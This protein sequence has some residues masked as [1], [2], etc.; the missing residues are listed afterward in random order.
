MKKSLFF[1][2]VAVALLAVSCNDD[3]FS[4]FPELNDNQLYYAGE[5]LNISP[6]VSIQPETSVPE[7]NY[8]DP[9]KYYVDFVTTD[10]RVSARMD[11]QPSTIG[12]TVDMADPIA[13]VGK[14]QYC[15]ALLD[16]DPMVWSIDCFEGQV[17]SQIGDNDYTTTCFKSGE[18]VTS[19]TS[20]GFVMEFKGIL[21]DDTEVAFRIKVPESDFIP[22]K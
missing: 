22:W 17:H 13:A 3:P 7:M 5:V 6:Q 14:A 1:S 8:Y 4:K 19:H 15:I 20:D 10:N 18:S 11:M 2:L 12:L 9:G 16:G 21:L